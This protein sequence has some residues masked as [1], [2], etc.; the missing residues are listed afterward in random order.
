MD[1]VLIMQQG[2]GMWNTSV[3]ISEP[4]SSTTGGLKSKRR[5]VSMPNSKKSISSVKTVASVVEKGVQYLDTRS[6]FWRQQM[7]LHTLNDILP[8][9]QHVIKQEQVH[10]QATKVKD[11]A[12]S[13]VNSRNQRFTAL[14][15]DIMRC[16]E[17]KWR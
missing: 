7:P 5:A 10:Q 14:M 16:N 2:I 6:T 9:A 8:L 3:F 12:E 1:Q 4:D 11:T 17:G 13:D 15:I